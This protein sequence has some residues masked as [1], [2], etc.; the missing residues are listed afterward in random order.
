MIGRRAGALLPACAMLTLAAPART[1]TP[2]PGVGLPWRP[3][4]FD[5]N[6]AYLR[7]SVRHGWWQP[8]KYI[9][10]GGWSSLSFGG[11]VRA[12]YERL[13]HPGFGALPTD[14]SG[15]ELARLM[16]HADWRLGRRLRLFGQ[17]ASAQE[18]GRTGGARPT[19]VDTLDV[20]Q[21]FVEFTQPIAPGRL[22]ARVGRQEL[23]VGGTRLF[24]IRD[25]AN[26]RRS[27]DAV[28]GGFAGQRVAVDLF[29]GRQV[30]VSPG[31]FDDPRDSTRYTCGAFGTVTL[32]RAQAWLDVY[33]FRDHRD[34][35]P[36]AQGTA[37]ANRWT[38]GAV[39]RGRRGQWE[40][41][42][43]GLYQWGRFGT[44][45]INAYDGILDVAYTF[46]TLWQPR[47]ALRGS[48]SSG[49]RNPS[50]PALQSLDPLYPRAVA[51]S[52][53]PVG[54]VNL[55]NVHPGLDLQLSRRLSTYVDLDVFWRTRN[56]D[57]IY[58]AGG[59]LIHTAFS[60]P[61]RYIGMQPGWELDWYIGPYV[62][63]ELAY[64]HFFP[65]PAIT[66]SGPGLAM[67]YVLASTTFTF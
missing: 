46:R 59:G 66:Q 40:W 15:Y 38:A 23:A 57:G 34:L 1:Q 27:F 64:A 37:P 10:I 54:P 50:D 12:E 20:R 4:R 18:A 39:S 53:A 6:Y 67:N 55:T 51:L 31:L 32:R 49:D 44:A 3:L 13:D 5:E 42:V 24:A 14:R 2:R 35:A 33:L 47:L 48:Q 36:F 9:P 30:L 56:T 21:A 7:D 28:R 60:T 25:P 45:P 43:E 61:A 16:L 29:W 62:H 11:E 19:D 58:D 26:V 63:A 41:N 52:G 17:L 22:W 8:L 65:G